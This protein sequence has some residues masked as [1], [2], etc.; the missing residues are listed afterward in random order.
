MQADDADHG[1]LEVHSGQ[2]SVWMDGTGVMHEM[3]AMSS[4]P[5]QRKTP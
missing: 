1:A 4:A 2:P 3:H 5:S